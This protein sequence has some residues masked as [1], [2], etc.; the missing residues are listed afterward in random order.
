MLFISDG[1]QPPGQLPALLNQTILI[2][3]DIYDIVSRF[4]ITSDILLKILQ[5]KTIYPFWN[6]PMGC[7]E[8]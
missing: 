5:T 8:R 7:K 4:Q 2:Q 6:Y 1:K 3:M